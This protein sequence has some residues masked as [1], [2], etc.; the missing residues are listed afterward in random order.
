MRQKE[1]SSKSISRGRNKMLLDS[2]TG[3]RSSHMGGQYGLHPD[4]SVNYSVESF[5]KPHAIDNSAAI[6]SAQKIREVNYK[7]RRRKVD[8]D[9][10][11]MEKNQL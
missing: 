9:R 2:K 5:M 7:H 10:E 4:E 11:D 6:F 8:Q 1:I 3:F